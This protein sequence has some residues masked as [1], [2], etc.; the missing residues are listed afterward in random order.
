MFLEKSRTNIEEAYQKI[1][2]DLSLYMEPIDQKIRTLPEAE[3]VAMRY[4]YACM[5]YSDIGNYPIETFLDFARHGVWLYEHKERVRELPEEIFARYVLCH[6]VN[7][8][9]IR[10]CR[11]LFYEQLEETLTGEDPQRTALEVNEWCAG[12]VTYEAGDDRTLS[13]LAV[14][15]RGYGR[16]GEESVFA[17]NALRSAGIPARQ[18]YA[19]YWS[20][21]DDNHAWVEVWI[22]GA[23][24]FLGACE[25]EPLL[26]LGWFEYAASRAMLIHT[27]RFDGRLIPPGEQE[28][29]EDLAVIEP[30]TNRYAD[31]IRKVEVTVQDAQGRALPALPVSFEVLNYAAFLPIARRC[32]DAEGKVSLVTGAGSL[33][34]T[35]TTKELDGEL[36]L[37]TRK[38]QTGLLRLSEKRKKG[39]EKEIWKDLDFIPPRDRPPVS[40]RPDPE[41]KA[42]ENRKLRKLKAKQ[43]KK[44]ADWENP[45]KQH[46]SIWLSSRSEAEQQLGKALFTTLTRKDQTDIRADV[47]RDHVEGA[48]LYRDSLP[49]ALFI[50]AVLNP[51]VED[52][53]LTPYRLW[54]QG[55]ICGQDQEACRK[56]PLSLWK[57]IQKKIR[58]CPEQERSTVLTTPVACYRM[59]CG[60]RRS[61]RVL[62]VAMARSFGI[63][64]RI[65]PEDGSVEFW[66]E[67]DW[68]SPEKQ[69]QA[70]LVLHTEDGEDWKSGQNWSITK[71]TKEYDPP[72]ALDDAGWKDGSCQFWLEEGT[73][74]ILTALR[75]PNGAVSAKECRIFLTA[76]D[77]RDVTL[78]LREECFADLLT[79]LALPEFSVL[80]LKGKAVSSKMLTEEG[81]HVLIWA[82]AGEEPTEHIFHELLEGRERF[83]ELA[84]RICLFVRSKEAWNHPLFCS[85]LQVF[86]E[87]QV[88]FDD[89]DGHVPSVG[90][91][92]YVDHE[93]L[94]MIAVTKGA[95]N[96]IYAVSGYQVGTVSLLLRIMREG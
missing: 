83:A 31:Q 62:F 67:G 10:P 24:H 18:V 19:P 17:V 52:E 28:W 79:S 59:R 65:S 47:L 73:Y 29:Q 63:P 95:Q 21:C 51:R 94:P 26:D 32:T 33:H 48:L 60:S 90:R 1:C 38:E 40:R 72:L 78:S 44:W 64:A 56:D 76:G 61:K 27:R 34:V 75:L 4:L 92:L 39:S 58:E 14:Y 15:E 87:M 2:S 66:K 69:K 9:E 23:W 86:P 49:E 30:V 55:E 13:A 42:E 91:R 20:H 46:F 80:D 82:G 88:Y 71:F 7:E 81:K 35:A 68:I 84:S 6:R 37:D 93:K 70:L 36:L 57:W 53:I 41:Q 89:F 50:D 25:P 12:E 22:Q 5:P 96:V 85:V 8:E 74:R 54:F 16:C 45:E 3:A 43:E 77:R 11:T